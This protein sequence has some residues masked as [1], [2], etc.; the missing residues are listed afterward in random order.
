MGWKESRVEHSQLSTYWGLGSLGA[1]LSSRA[2]GHHH[3]ISEGL[4]GWEQEGL[5]TRSLVSLEM[6]AGEG[7]G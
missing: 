4:L 6:L 1:P 7:E 3:S 5:A 2:V